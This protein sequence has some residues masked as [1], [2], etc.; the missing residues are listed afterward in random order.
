MSCFILTFKIS[1]MFG[2]EQARVLVW[3][4][5]G[6]RLGHHGTWGGLGRTILINWHARAGIVPIAAWTRSATAEKSGSRVQVMIPEWTEL[7]RWS[8]W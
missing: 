6:F 1:M 5:S 4:E 8:L 7:V 3:D 2:R